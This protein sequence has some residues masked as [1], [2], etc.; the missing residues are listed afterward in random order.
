MLGVIIEWVVAAVRVTI[1]A[2]NW[3]NLHR[4]EDRDRGDRGR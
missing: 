3:E 1:P 2:V 4:K